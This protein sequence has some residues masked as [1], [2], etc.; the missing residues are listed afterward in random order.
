[1]GRGADD[2]PLYEPPAAGSYALPALARVHARELVDS[3]G[4]RVRF[5][6]LAKGQVA[7]V[8]FVYGSCHDA[9]GCPASLAF[10]RDLDRRLAADPARAKRARLV[11]VSFDPARDTPAHLAELRGLMAPQSDWSFL[12]PASQAELAP[13]LREFGQDVAALADGSLRH[14]AKIYLVD[15]A[16][17]VRNVYAPGQ[18]DPRLVLADIDTVAPPR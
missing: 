4:A 17:Q 15:A 10:M 12:V 2:A 8:A 9:A 5:P 7:V 3:T 14:V 16:L 18:L 1:M 6:G 13:L 11:C